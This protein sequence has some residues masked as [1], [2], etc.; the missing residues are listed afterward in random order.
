MNVDLE[1]SAV[2]KVVKTSGMT[3]PIETLD[4]FRY[5]ETDF[6]HAES[7]K[8][9]PAASESLEGRPVCLRTFR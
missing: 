2:A 1:A 8:L 9:K 3:L 7:A 4:E 6:A 5:P